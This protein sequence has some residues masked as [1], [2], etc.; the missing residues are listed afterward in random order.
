[1][2]QCMIR[3]INKLI[4]VDFIHHYLIKKMPVF[5]ENAAA[6]HINYNKI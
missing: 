6:T 4:V 2:G 5:K 3:F 1:M